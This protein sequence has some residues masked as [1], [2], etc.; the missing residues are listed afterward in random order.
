MA[1]TFRG[2]A[3]TK[4]VF[5]VRSCRVSDKK[6]RLSAFHVCRKMYDS[7]YG[8]VMEVVLLIT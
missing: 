1:R 2:K 5:I 3:N 4:L 7:L 8:K 6:S